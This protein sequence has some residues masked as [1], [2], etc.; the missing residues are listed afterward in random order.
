MDLIPAGYR[1]APR[2]KVAICSVA[3]ISS[4]SL[5]TSG[6]GLVQVPFFAWISATVA[7]AGFACYN[8]TGGSLHFRGVTVAGVQEVRFWTNPGGM[9]QGKGLVVETTGVAG[10]NEFHVYAVV[11]R[12]GIGSAATDQ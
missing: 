2:T 9:A 7:G 4:N 3:T 11:I 12:G 1:D 8:G 5:A 10:I 6:T